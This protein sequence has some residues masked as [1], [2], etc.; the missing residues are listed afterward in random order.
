[1]YKQKDV[2]TGAQFVKVT[3]NIKKVADKFTSSHPFIF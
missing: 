1:M 2:K 3:Q